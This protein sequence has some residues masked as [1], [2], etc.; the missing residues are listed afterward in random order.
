[1]RHTH[2]RCAKVPPAPFTMPPNPK[3]KSPHPH[4]T[5]ALLLL[6]PLPLPLHVCPSYVLQPHPKTDRFADLQRTERPQLHSQRAKLLS[7]ALDAV[8]PPPAALPLLPASAGPAAG[9]VDLVP[10]ANPVP[11][12]AQGMQI[13]K[14]HFADRAAPKRRPCN[15][16]SVGAGPQVHA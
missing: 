16:R 3:S 12:P 13:L 4:L 6:P 5:P 14:A 11:V 7:A 10:T 9:I 8:A 1:M 15:H 2:G